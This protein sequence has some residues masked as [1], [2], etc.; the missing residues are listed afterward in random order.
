MQTAALLAPALLFGGMV[1]FSSGF[2][3]F[4]FSALPPAAAGKALRQ[5]FPH[6][7][8]FVIV[9]S[10]AGSA[11]LLAYDALSAALLAAIF[12][13][14]VPTRQILMPAINAAT[15]AGAR[16]RFQILHGASVAITLAHI[17]AS[18]YVLAR[19]LDHA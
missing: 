12:L 3:A 10:A 8:L 1:L 14:T 19:F 11:L 4:L 17:A 5:A 18:G 15:D 2:A 7:Y 13:S 9:T 6:F 16:R